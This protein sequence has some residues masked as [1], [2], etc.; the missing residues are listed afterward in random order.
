[1]QRGRDSQETL[2]ALLDA[3]AHYE[4]VNPGPWLVAYWNVRANVL[5][6][7]YENTFG[8]SPMVALKAANDAITSFAGPLPDDYWFLVALIDCRLAEAMYRLRNGDDIT[9][10]LDDAR[11]AI[12]KGTEIKSTMPLDLR[13]R[14][15]EIEI[16]AIT[17]AKQRG[18]LDK[19]HFD[20]ALEYVRDVST[21]PG[22]DALL[23]VVHAEVLALHAGWTHERRGDPTEYINAG[24]A[25]VAAALAMYPRMPRATITKGNLLIVRSQHAR[26]DKERR[27]AASQAMNAFNDAFRENPLLEREHA[28]SYKIANNLMQ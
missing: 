27:E 10:M 20:Q 12:K 14:A 28:S 13:Y 22:A 25:S 3:V 6:A 15:A 1:M 21:I 19:A 23:Y 16:L 18:L 4:K 11:R 17:Y 24:L 8:R 26:M 5:H 9:A 2:R 7:Q